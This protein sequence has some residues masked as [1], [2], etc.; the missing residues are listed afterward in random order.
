MFFPSFGSQQQ[1]LPISFGLEIFLLWNELLVLGEP[2]RNLAWA[3]AAMLDP[4][5]NQP[6]ALHHLIGPWSWGTEGKN[7][8]IPSGWVG[9]RERILGLLFERQNCSFRCGQLL[10]E[11]NSDTLPPPPK[12]GW[13]TSGTSLLPQ[14]PASCWI[15]GQGGE[16]SL[17]DFRSPL[18]RCHLT[19]YHD[20]VQQG[21][22]HSL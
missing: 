13:H 9:V 21:K 5:I 17:R 19:P 22:R 18:G 7:G 1:C 16:L 8:R 12:W 15:S 14:T 3:G 20:E 10:T 11:V 4:S 6:Q 2:Y